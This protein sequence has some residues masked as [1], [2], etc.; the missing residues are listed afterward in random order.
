MKNRIFFLLMLSVLISHSSICQTGNYPD[1]VIIQNGANV[2]YRAFP[3][4][5][6]GNTAYSYFPYI[7]FNA[8]LTKSDVTTGVNEFT[9]QFSNGSG[10]GGLIIKGEAGA[11]GLHFLQRQYNSNPGPFNL[12]TFK[13]VMTLNASG[14]LGLGTTSPATKLQLS[15]NSTTLSP[16]NFFT[17]DNRGDN[18]SYNTSHVIGG[19]LFSG[20]RDIRNPANIAG[21]WAIRAPM[22]SGLASQG[23]LVFGAANNNGTNLSMDNALPTE[24]MRISSLGNVLI[25]RTTQINTSFKLDV[26]G[27]VHATKVV[28]NSDGADFVFDSSYK[29]MP[30]NEVADFISS[31][32]HLP[33]ITPAS[34]MQTNGIDLGDNQTKLLQKIEEVTLYLIEQNKQLITQNK[35]IQQLTA[36]NNQL[37]QQLSQIEEMKTLMAHQQAAIEQL[38][39][40]SKQTQTDHK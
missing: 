23:D 6:M 33:E 32:R 2:Y 38:Q 24:R 31:H 36:D 37:K 7:S 26:N 27:P 12:N 8:V 22:S 17:I 34:D 14:F 19:I 21:I 18:A 4:L 10:A 40:E 11:S 20:Y 3:Y 30:L 35:K 39:N 1:G 15:N 29:L 25:G 16:Y 28:V 13:D 5:T 9:P